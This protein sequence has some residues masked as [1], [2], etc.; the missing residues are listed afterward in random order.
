M[1][2]AAASPHRSNSISSSVFPKPVYSTPTPEATP[3]LGSVPPG[4]PFGGFNIAGNAVHETVRLAQAW[5]VVTRYLTILPGLDLPSKTELDSVS[6]SEA[7]GLLLRN[8]S[9]ARELLDWYI[10]EVDYHFRVYVAP[11]LQMWNQPV[12]AKDALERVLCILNVLQAAQRLYSASLDNIT[13]RLLKAST[14]EDLARPL[15]AFIARYKQR[16]HALALHSLPLDKLRKTLSAAFYQQMAVSLQQRTNP[17]SC[18]RSDRCRCR[19]DIDS[20]PLA[21]LHRIGLGGNLGERAFAYAVHN[22]LE[23]PAVE[24]RC[25]AVDWTSQGSV[26]PRLRD[27]T[28]TILAPT[29]ERAHSA[30]NGNEDFTFSQDEVQRLTTTAI[31]HIGRQRTAALFDYVR[32]W[33]ESK[34]AVLDIKEY[35]AANANEKAHLCSSFTTQV[36]Q[37]ILHAGASTT[38]I[39]SIYINMIHVFRLLDAR[40]VLLEKVAIPIRNYLRTR[41]DTVNI[42]AASFLA[43]LTE[44]GELLNADDEKVCVDIAVEVEKSTLEDSRESKSLGWDDMEWM[45]DPI[46][47]GPNYKASKPEDVITYVLGLFEQEEFLKEVTNVLAQHLLQSNDNEY[48]KETRLVELFKSR[49]DATKLQ[50][51]EVMLKDMRD[52]LNL[53][54]KFYKSRRENA[55]ATRLPTPREIQEAIPTEGI[56]LASLYKIFEH[57]IKQAQFIATVKLVANRRNDLFYPKRGRLPREAPEGEKPAGVFSQL[58]FRL[59]VVSGFFWPQMR[60]NDFWMPSGYDEY[61]SKTN[62]LFRSYGGQRKLH[63]KPAVTRVSLEL[64][65]EDRKIVETD[66]PAW[67][68]SVIDLFASE[69][70]PSACPGTEVEYDDAL[71]FSAE[72]IGEHLR[73]EEELVQDALSYWVGKRVLYERSQRTYAVIERLDMDL[74]AAQLHVQPQAEE[75]SAIKSQDAVLRENAAMFEMFIANMLR[76][77]GP[78]EVGGMMGITPLLKMVLPTFTYGEDEVRWLLSEM[79]G[80]GEVVRNGE[81]YAVA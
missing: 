21:A 65:L 74:S 28:Q 36:Q 49:F 63:W 27:W 13:S 45:P 22:L 66:I 80:R 10:H 68:A 11:E 1:A 41:D 62:T 75:F 14:D 16:W 71:G 6:A 46:D 54:K 34:G 61:Q 73:M 2:A 60:E 35:L 20:L 78:K 24:R 33:P 51:A 77:S 3:D 42:I 48:I 15:R 5:S 43:E 12:S 19:L 64:E 79:E 32:S 4:Q 9:K 8:G 52:S 59:Q 70:P 37:R 29:V 69:R 23:G 56:S 76:N 47:A 58:D 50:A 53:E 67:R 44:D 40:G 25:F 7:L 26:M 31:L 55:S 57:R 18:I 38:E 81:T 30:F 17:E 72:Q 39:L